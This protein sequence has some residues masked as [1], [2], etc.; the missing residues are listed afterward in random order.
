MIQPPSNNWNQTP[1]QDHNMLGEQA[2]GSPP[3][4][5]SPGIIDVM[6]EREAQDKKWGVQNHAPQKWL[7]ILME[8]L[9]EAAEQ[10]LQGT[11]MGYR[12]E[13]VQVAAVAVA[14]IEGLDRGW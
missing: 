11:R 2:S 13:M 1:P 7:A 14:A 10:T 9:G 8:E 6:R 5:C 12:R 3:A 4:P